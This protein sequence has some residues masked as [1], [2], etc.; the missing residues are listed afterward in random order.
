M[1]AADVRDNFNDIH[2]GHPHEATNI[3]EPLGTPVLAVVNG[4]IRKLFL[5]KPDGITIYEFEQLR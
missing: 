2:N 5:S 4:Q 3:M 1:K